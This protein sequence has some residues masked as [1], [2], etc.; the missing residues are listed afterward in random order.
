ML[1][2]KEIPTEER[3]TFQYPK[4]FDFQTLKKKKGWGKKN[5]RSG[6]STMSCTNG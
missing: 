5:L 2:S 1:D 6:E 3:S 4:Q